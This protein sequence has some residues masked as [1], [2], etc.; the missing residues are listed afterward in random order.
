MDIVDDALVPALHQA[1]HHV[2]AHPTQSDHA[3]LH[4]IHLLGRKLSRTRHDRSGP[5][6]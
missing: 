3:E 4:V 5:C 6:G 2:G 1:A